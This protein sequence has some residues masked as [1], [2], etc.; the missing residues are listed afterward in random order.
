M[1]RLWEEHFDVEMLLDVLIWRLNRCHHETSI[2]VFI[3]SVKRWG[4]ILEDSQI[5][6]R[7]V[8]RGELT[9]LHEQVASEIRRAIADGE[10]M[11][12]Q[13]I[14]Q[15]K[16]LAKVLNVNTNTVLRALRLLRDEGLVE[17]GRGRAIIVAG[18]PGRTIVV[19]KLREL[20]AFARTQ[21]YRPDELVTMMQQLS[22]H[23][24]SAGSRLKSSWQPQGANLLHAL[25]VQL[26]PFVAPSRQ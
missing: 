7:E 2:I 22:L 21:G 13:R 26:A 17:M 25:H 5:T 1:P 23:N 9:L 10:A 3:S 14:P 12:G 4:Q 16:D 18:S 19:E 6:L 15:A 11:P 8:D 20:I 24:P